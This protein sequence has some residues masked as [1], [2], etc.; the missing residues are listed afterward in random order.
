[1]RQAAHAEGRCPA[2]LTKERTKEALLQ[3]T[4]QLKCTC[5]C[6]WET[7]ECAHAFKSIQDAM[8]GE[9]TGQSVPRAPKMKARPPSAR[10]AQHP[11]RRHKGAQG[12][13]RRRAPAARSEAD[14]AT[15]L[16]ATGAAAAATAAAGPPG[17][18]AH[19]SP[20]RAPR[21]AVCIRRAAG[22]PPLERGPRRPLTQTP[23]AHQSCAT[24]TLLGGE[25][26]LG[27]ATRPGDPSRTSLMCLWPSAGSS[28]PP[29]EYCARCCCCCC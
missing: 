5:M 22:G 13:P 24:L 28:S 8:A 25:A 15:Q 2:T 12:R 3:L 16:A 21:R 26:T 4:L 19:A 7:R 23:A 1:M 6:R 29:R 11:A 17:A 27:D 18:S 20:G 10:G 14:P 9:W